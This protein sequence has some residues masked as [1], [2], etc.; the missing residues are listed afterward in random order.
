MEADFVQ[1]LIKS[2]PT[3]TAW[4][5][6]DQTRNA[7]RSANRNPEWWEILVN[8]SKSRISN[9]SVSFGTNSNLRLWT[10]RTL[11]S[12]VSYL[13]VCLFVG[14]KPEKLYSSR[15]EGSKP[16]GRGHTRA[17]AQTATCIPDSGTNHVLVNPLL[18]PCKLTGWLASLD[19]RKPYTRHI[20]NHRTASPHALHGVL[21][22]DGGRLTLWQVEIA[23]YP[24]TKND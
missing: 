23:I 12:P 17:E 2:P 15:W 14:M 4:C 18:T 22:L 3:R 8:Q 13:F 16:P 24:L 10:I 5:M 1:D 6:E 21:V 11:I 9:F 19:L 20:R 7:R